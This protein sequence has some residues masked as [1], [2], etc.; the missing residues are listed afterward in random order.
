MSKIFSF[1]STFTGDNHVQFEASVIQLFLKKFPY[2]KIVLVGNDYHVSQVTNLLSG[3]VEKQVCKSSSLFFINSFIYF[4]FL[5]NGKA[6]N[7]HLSADSTLSIITY[8]F[9]L[10]IQLD[11]VFIHGYWR[12]RRYFLWRLLHLFLLKLFICLHPKVK[13]LLLGQWIFANIQKDRCLSVKEKKTF[14]WLNH[15]YIFKSD[16]ILALSVSPVF[17][18]PWVLG[19]KF[20]RINN[21]IFSK[22]ISCISVFWWKSI[23]SESV[24]LTRIEYERIFLNSNYIVLLYPPG[25]YDYR[26]SWVFIEAIM[27]IKPVICLSSCMT[28]YFFSTYGEIWYNCCDLQDMEK[29]IRNLLKDKNQERY[30]RQITNMK[31][32]QNT[33]LQSS[34]N[35]SQ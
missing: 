10:F 16:E 1:F 19:K 28:D 11:I 12:W 15:P 17:G 7:V 21:E 33:I 18:F 6:C 23:S 2:S 14:F 32:A 30:L 27:F 3:R 22:I 20:K 34:L 25:A 31:R 4:R 5:L 29:V 9:T 8:F 35:L 26:C 24:F 13:N